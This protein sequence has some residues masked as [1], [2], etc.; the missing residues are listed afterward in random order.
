MLSPCVFWSSKPIYAGFYNVVRILQGLNGFSAILKKISKAEGD[1]PPT[2]DSSK[3]II[4][5]IQLHVLSMIHEKLMPYDPC[6]A[7]HTNKHS[8]SVEEKNIS[9]QK[10]EDRFVG[11]TSKMV[12]QKPN[13]QLKHILKVNHKGSSD[14][15]PPPPHLR[16]IDS[17]QLPQCHLCLK[18]FIS[19]VEV[20]DQ[21]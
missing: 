14:R 3:G 21:D 18:A 11:I 2:F 13:P 4:H 7:L 10:I 9:E 1:D 6:V 19:E 12:Y 20:I 5:R 15:K 8:I 17:S 16:Q